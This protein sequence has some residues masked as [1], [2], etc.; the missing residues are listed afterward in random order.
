MTDVPANTAA[1]HSALAASQD[2]TNPLDG[3]ILPRD[4]AKSW[5]CHPR[6]IRRMVARH[7]LPRPIAIGR[8]VYFSIAG[9][10]E[11]LRMRTEAA[12]ATPTRKRKGAR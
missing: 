8:K 11:H 5:N 4:L 10:R 9:I 2:P 12:N 3:F 7:E 1:S 6:T